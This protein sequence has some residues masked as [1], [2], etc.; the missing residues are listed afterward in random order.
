MHISSLRLWEVCSASFK[1]YVH[2]P[3]PLAAEPAPLTTSSRPVYRN[4]LFP[5]TPYLPPLP[6]NP[7]LSP[8]HFLQT[9]PTFQ[10][11]VSCSRHFHPPIP[12][13]PHATLSPNTLPP[14]PVSL[15]IVSLI[16]AYLPTARSTARHHPSRHHLYCAV[17]FHHNYLS[18]NTTHH[19]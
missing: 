4:L 14:T 10:P 13:L 11:P 18:H 7:L 6:L 1:S 8:L 3:T 2:P 12:H 19:A 16:P 5:P 9:T 15:P 17:S